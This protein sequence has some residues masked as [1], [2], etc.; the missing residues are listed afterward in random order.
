MA[1]VKMGRKGRWNSEIKALRA[2][3]VKL[4]EDV[5]NG[6]VRCRLCKGF[7]HQGDPRNHG[8]S[9]DVGR[10]VAGPAP[11]KGQESK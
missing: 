6:Y 9:C 10:A 4:G 7:W 5:D 11:S 8:A 1:A 2:L 3:V